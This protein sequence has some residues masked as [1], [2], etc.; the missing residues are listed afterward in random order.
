M[1]EYESN[2]MVTL[3]G[4]EFLRETPSG[5]AEVWRLA[6]DEEVCVPKSLTSRSADGFLILPSWYVKRGLA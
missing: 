1:S 3:K 4:S 2:P 5:M 6:D